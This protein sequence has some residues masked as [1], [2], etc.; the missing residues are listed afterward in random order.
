MRIH[1][2]EADWGHVSEE[3]DFF[4]TL[5]EDYDANEHQTVS[6]RLDLLQLGNGKYKI[7]KDGVT[8]CFQVQLGKV[9]FL[10]LED[11]SL[12]LATLNASEYNH[13]QIAALRMIQREGLA[14]KKQKD[15]LYHYSHHEDLIRIRR[16]S[17]SWHILL[18]TQREL[19]EV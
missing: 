15:I 13:R 9:W 3:S 16:S 7:V 1:K 8:E 18:L 14:S 5:V 4:S 2:L 17:L 11:F 6:N 19:S 10:S 12:R